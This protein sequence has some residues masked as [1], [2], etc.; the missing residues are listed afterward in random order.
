MFL[1]LF[2]DIS[3]DK[4][5]NEWWETYDENENKEMPRNPKQARKELLV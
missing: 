3:S 5:R 4:V 1:L 2:G